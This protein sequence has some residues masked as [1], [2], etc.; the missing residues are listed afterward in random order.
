[1]EKSFNGKPKKLLKYKI[2]AQMKV[3]LL[4]EV[5]FAHLLD[6]SAIYL[7]YVFFLMLHKFKTSAIFYLCNVDFS[8]IRITI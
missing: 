3:Q 5:V 1:M 8:S 2:V 6:C 4:L 7:L